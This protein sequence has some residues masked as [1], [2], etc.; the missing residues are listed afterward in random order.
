MRTLCALTVLLLLTAC[1]IGSTTT[2]RP[3]INLPAIGPDGAFWDAVGVAELDDVE[4]FLYLVSPQ[5]V[6]ARFMPTA[7][8]PEV[9]TQN[10]LEASRTSLLTEA[11]RA[12]E[13]HQLDYNSELYRLS[14][15]YMAE[16]RKLMDDRFVEVG[17]PTYEIEFRDEF[18]RASG[19]NRAAV[20]VR[21]YP[22]SRVPDGYVPETLTVLFIQ[23]GY[24]WLIDGLE[25]DPLWGAYAFPQ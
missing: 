9:K 4:K 2:E 8:R 25:P 5:F 23:D 17:T 18:G 10:E 6:H 21:V 20:Q 11:Q 19:P 24:R 16:L 14:Y 15:G 7:R 13:R 12:A 1:T 3:A 22:K